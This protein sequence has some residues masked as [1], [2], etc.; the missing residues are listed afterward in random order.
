MEATCLA[1]ARPNICLAYYRFN[2]QRGFAV[3]CRLA[4]IGQNCFGGDQRQC[5]YFQQ[6]LFANRAC[7]LESNQQACIFLRQQGF[8]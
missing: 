7:A 6:L 2:C 3:A 8:N 4:S 5:N 1:Q